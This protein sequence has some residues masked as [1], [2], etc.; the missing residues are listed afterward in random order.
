M[1]RIS[2]DD[3]S[4]NVFKDLRNNRLSI[5]GLL[6]VLVYVGLTAGA[7]WLVA[8]ESLLERP[9]KLFTT[10]SGRVD[11][12]LSCHKEEKLNPA[13]DAGVIGCASCHLGNPLAVAKEEA[14]RGMVL[15]P[16]DLRHVEKTC[17]VEGC[18]PTDAHKVKNSLMATN[19]GILGTLLYYWGESESQD[20]ELTVEE[21]LQNGGAKDSL[22]LD[23]FRKL[24]STCHLW[25]QKNDLPGLPQFF[26]EKGGGCSAC[27]YQKPG[28]PDDLAASLV[29]DHEKLPSTREEK[30]LHPHITKEVTST[31][32]IRCH[33]RSGRIGLS[34]AGI[35]ESE[36]YGTPY[37]DGRPNHRQLPG[38]RFYLELADDVHHQKGMECIDCHTRGEIMGDGTSYAHYE[39]Q[40]EISCEVCH[41]KEPGVTRKDNR[42]NNLVEEG[43]KVFL[44][45][46]VDQKEHPVKPAKQGVCNFPAHKRLTCE[47]CHSTWVAQCYGCHAKRD[48]SRTHLDKLSLTET[49]G[50]WEEGRSYIR[51]ERPMLGVWK[52]EI[53]VVTPGCQDIVTV[54]DEKGEIDRSFDRFTMAAI[55]PHTTQA[56]GRE[57]ADCHASTKTV[58]LGEGT[59]AERDGKLVFTGIDQG[60]TTSVG[61]TV[62]FDA[63]VTLEGEPLQHSSR[64]ELRPFNGPELKAILRVGLCVR[65]HDRYDD[66]AWQGYTEATVCRRAGAENEEQL[67]NTSQKSQ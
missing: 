37:Q 58:G 64:P 38:A 46:K 16:G 57:C 56:K 9:D 63:Y 45:G 52:E 39:E 47:A 6:K 26:S 60:V 19:R 49:P 36:G 31:S 42:L 30:K 27:H 13:H 2:R 66:P 3:S 15:N 12:C 10:S 55:N 59:I 1:S 28:R 20:T 65:C 14:H 18:H 22:A 4:S 54:V 23:Y 62:P 41:G 8:R 5:A 7:V 61:P 32:C 11:M 17:S 48:A 50:L 24:C 53:V 33:N 35:F 44:T 34:Y 25:K 43:G 67:F 51:Y 29:A 21:L 40:L